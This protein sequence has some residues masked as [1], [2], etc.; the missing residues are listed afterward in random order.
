M[1]VKDFELTPQE[2]DKTNEGEMEELMPE[3]VE[4]V[5]HQVDHLTLTTCHFV[6]N[7][8]KSMLQEP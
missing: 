1:G 2:E 5:L 7:S 8:W 4:M 6:C 3:L